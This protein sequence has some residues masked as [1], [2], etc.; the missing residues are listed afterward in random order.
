[1]FPKEPEVNEDHSTHEMVKNLHSR[2]GAFEERID[3]RFCQIENRIVV[4]EKGLAA[5]VAHLDK[6]EAEACLRE[7][8]VLKQLGVLTVRFDKHAEREEVDR[9]WLLGIVLIT[10]IGSI[11]SLLMLVLT[12]GAA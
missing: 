10:M 4:V 12:G 11:G 7:S 1:V 6:H 8:A 5:D 9:R 3:E 2:F